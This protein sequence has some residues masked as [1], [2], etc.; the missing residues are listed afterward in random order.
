MKKGARRGAIPPVPAFGKWSLSLAIIIA[1]CIPALGQEAKKADTPNKDNEL[2]EIVK[3]L[4]ALK[5]RVEAM[6]KGGGDSAAT[7]LAQ[8]SS[9]KTDS[10]LPAEWAKMMKWRSIGPAGMGGRITAISV[11]EADPSTYWVATASGGL[12]KTDN[13]GITF[14]HQFDHEASVSIGDVCVAPSD[15]NIVWVGTGENNPRNSVSYGDGVYKSTDGGKTWKNMGLKATFQIGRV[16]VHPKNPDIVYVG[17]LGRLYGANADRGLYKTTDGGKNWEKILYIDDKTGVIDIAM[18]PTDPETLII[19]MWERERNRFDSL[20]GEPP[21]PDGLDAYD[22]M[23]KWGPGAGIHKTIDGGKTFKKLTK[24]LP[25]SNLGRMDIEYYRKD[26]NTVYAIIDCEQIGKGIPPSRLYLGVQGEDTSGG[27]KITTVT[28]NSPASK[29][30]LKAGDVVKSADKKPIA[31]YEELAALTTGRKAGDKLALEILR[32]GKTEEISLT[33]EERPAGQGGGR[34]FGGGGG[35]GGGGFGGGGPGGGAAGLP[36]LLGAMVEDVEGGVRLVRVMDERNAEKAGLEE[37]DT[38][39]EIEGT[40]IKSTEQLLERLRQAKEGDKLKIKALRD[41]E[42]KELTLTLEPPGGM[43]RTR[44]YTYMYGGQAPNV[45]T[46]QGPN[47]H[48]YGGI[49]KSTDGGE[50][51]TRINSLNPRPMYFSQIRVDPS[52]D[53]F[54]YVLGV[55]MYRSKDGGKTFT[56]DG[57]RRVHSDQHALWIDARDGRHMIVGC[58]GGFYDTYDRMDHWAHLN[59]VAIGQFYHVALDNRYPYHM[60]GGLQD[61]GSWGGPSRSLG[62]GGPIN[63]DWVEVGGGDGFVCRVDPFDADLIYSESQDGNMAR[64]NLRTGER[65]AIRPRRERGKKFRFNWNTPFILSNHNAGIYYAAGNYVFRSVKR[66]EDLRVISPEISRTGRGT[67]SALAESPRNPDILWVGTDDGNLWVSKDGG[68]KWTN[69]ADKIGL[70]GPRWVATIEPSR[71]A[72]GRCYV[73]FDAHRSN[74]DEPYLYVTEDFGETWKSLRANLPTGSTR[75]LREDFKNHE[76]LFVG[77]EFGVWVSLNRGASWTQLNSSLPTVAVHELAIHPTAGEMVAA[78]HGRSLWV[79][80]I[81]PLR[82][83]TADSLKSIVHL[84]EPN[85][86]IRWRPEPLKNVPSGDQYFYGENPPRGVQIYYRLT[87]KAEKANLKVVDINGKTVRELTARTEAGLHQIPWDLALGGRGGRFGAGGGGGRGGFGGGG[88][89]GAGGAGRGGAGG[90]GAGGGGGAAAG[91]QGEGPPS[92]SGGESPTPPEGAP[93]GPP[94][95]FRLASVPAGVYRIVLTIDGKEY[96]Q[97]LRVDADPT[98]PFG[99]TIADP[100]AQEEDDEE[101]EEHEREQGGGIIDRIDD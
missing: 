73:A 29:A 81:T 60:Y 14:A 90:G 23:K 61:N 34:G 96:A 95:G 67:A 51:W 39:Q 79:I 45:Q 12:L 62:G 6:Q 84:Y 13:N 46:Q 88:G 72:D 36:G 17:A 48:E 68:A 101:E 63:T 4:D 50:S 74:D 37:G 26:P 21:L 49:Y 24:G 89:G 54:V 25:T 35:G 43:A 71:A 92:P 86:A 53:K 59:H 69:I 15:K 16:V 19:A 57:G 22:P 55:S 27:A 87:N 75:C 18:H 38:I 7:K 47:S 98:L 33:L 42:T 41:K 91:A 1:V 58:D 40:A 11:Y 83:M 28:N 5:K 64:R 97:T 8:A 31:N 70:P 94:G 52:D 80:D 2:A 9:P 66:G 77:T 10:A 100:L 93:Q 3:Q 30:G 65:L 85:P 56:N 76:L 44:P 32:E 82:Q 20:R 99:V 78:T